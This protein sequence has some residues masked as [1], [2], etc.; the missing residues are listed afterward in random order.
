MGE[1]VCQASAASA[2]HLPLQYSVAVYT[3]T[4]VH[5]TFSRASRHA[6]ADCAPSPQAA[7]RRWQDQGAG[8]GDPG[9]GRRTQESTV[10][11]S[12]CTVVLAAAPL[13]LL[14][15]AYTGYTAH[16]VLSRAEP[17]RFAKAKAN[18]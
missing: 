2:K 17:D 9:P 12:Q 5:D 13:V 18:L 14:A 1:G 4:T 7:A 6:S 8:P 11:K 10:L 16:S 3:Q 15:T